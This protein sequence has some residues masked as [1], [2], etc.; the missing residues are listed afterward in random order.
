MVTKCLLLNEQSLDPVHNLAMESALLARAKSGE[1]VL[2][3]WQNQNTVVIGRNQDAWRE[4]RISDLMADGGRLVRRPTG[5]GAVFHDLGNLNFSFILSKEDY[6]VPR[7]L[8]VVLA[9]LRAFGLEA[10]ASGRNDITLNG[11]KFSGNAFL[12]QDGFCLHHGTLLVDA[13]LHKMSSYLMP[14]E[15][16]L[17][18]KGIASVRARVTNLHAVCEAVT[19]PALRNA[20]GVALGTVYGVPAELLAQP[21]PDDAV[22]CAFEEKYHS[23]AWIFGQDETFDRVVHERFAWGEGRLGISVREGVIAEAV[24][25]TD[26]MDVSLAAA[27]RSALVGRLFTLASLTDLGIAYQGT[28]V[29]DMTELL[30]ITLEP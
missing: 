28:P 25:H 1:C 24:L 29:G 13:D 6:D 21:S 3:L 27:M 11:F 19:V 2:Y 18:S 30:K 26:A 5:G 22:L 14:S 23:N 17:K 4:C 8:S 15:L 10:E 9:A 16:K 7:Q 20:L 12:A